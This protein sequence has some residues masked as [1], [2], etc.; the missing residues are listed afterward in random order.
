[1]SKDTEDQLMITNEQK[2][3]LEKLAAE[4]KFVTSIRKKIFMIIMNAEDYLDALQ[5]LLKLKLNRKESKDIA[6]VITE[7]CAQEQTFNK[8]YV[9][10]IEKLSQIKKELK[11]SFQYALWDQ[12]K[13]LENFGLRKICNIAKLTAYLIRKAV[14][15]LGS[16]KGIELEEKNDHHLLFMKAFLK[17]FFEKFFFI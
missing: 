9:F 10:L 3:Y 8:F 11:F 1:L 14:I 2:D 12:F 7:C 17:T 5:N 13:L 16:L 4:Q 6:I 15:G